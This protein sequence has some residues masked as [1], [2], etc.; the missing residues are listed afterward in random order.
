MN[1]MKRLPTFVLLAGFLAA[2]GESTASGPDV[3]LRAESLL[4]AG[5]RDGL[6]ALLASPD[7]EGLTAA[8]RVDIEAQLAVAAGDVPKAERLCR[9]H[10]ESHPGDAR[11][12]YT[13]TDIYLNLG[14]GDLAREVI[15]R[16]L[17]V[18]PD[19]CKMH[20]FSGV[21]HGS[22]A[23]LD[24][25]ASAF[26]AAEACGF[27]SPELEYNLAVLEQNQGRVDRSIERL[28]SLRESRPEWRNVRREL[29][30]GLIT[31][32]DPASM[33]E[34]QLILDELSA[35]MEQEIVIDDEHDGVGQGD[36]RVWELLGLHA[37]KQGD[38]LAAQAYFVEGL[39]A[40]ENPIQVE[41]HYLRVSEAL[42]ASGMGEMVPVREKNKDMPPIS[43]GMQEQFDEARRK[44]ARAA[45]EAGLE[46]DGDQH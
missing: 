22:K 46:P 23:R 14:A 24:Q 37:E 34:A 41:E 8:A 20:Y 9:E 5:D 12:A 39:K 17:A 18:N 35:L 30:R 1:T 36:W 13:L 44:K 38:L 19:A 26:E 4:S 27:S 15:D 2:C 32:G 11:V 25:A 7:A 3:M 10:L 28:R 16:T 45:A 42:Q 40:G 6:D 43:A 21:L 33:D 29:A 31:K